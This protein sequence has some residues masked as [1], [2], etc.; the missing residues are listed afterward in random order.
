MA[1]ASSLRYSASLPSATGRNAGAVR[2]DTV[3]KVGVVSNGTEW[4]EFAVGPSALNLVDGKI[5]AAAGTTVTFVQS[6]TLATAAFFVAPAAC[7]ITS[8]VEVHA[9]AG[10]DA[11]AVSCVV[12]KDTG[13]AAPGAGTSVMTNTFDL[14]GTANTAQVATLAAAN[15]ITLARGDRLAIKLTGTPTTLAGAIVGLQLIW[16]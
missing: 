5:A 6:G 12:T 13:T 7:K 3:N 2:Y 10:N 8:I 16:V 14:K 9:T 15:T 1:D 4:V 11:G